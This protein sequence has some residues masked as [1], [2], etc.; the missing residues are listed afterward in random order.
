MPGPC[1]KQAETPSTPVQPCTRV[2]QQCTNIRVPIKLKPVANVGEIQSACCGKPEVSCHLLK[3]GDD[4][5]YE[6]T[7]TQSLCI[8]IP[9]EY[10]IEAD[11]GEADLSKYIGEWERT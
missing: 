10:G 1:Q 11:V 9:I 2:V 5:V 4:T 7:I 6:L 3:C 8:R